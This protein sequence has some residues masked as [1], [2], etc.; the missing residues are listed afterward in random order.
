MTSS[1]LLRQRTPQ[2]RLLAAA[3]AC[4]ENSQTSDTCVLTVGVNA[5]A[6]AP[7]AGSYVSCADAGTPCTTPW[8]CSARWRRK[9]NGRHSERR[10]MPEHE[11][12]LANVVAVFTC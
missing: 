2:V 11:L 8:P 1:I 3:L 9:L 7:G 12:D 4:L 10:N 5:R 6:L